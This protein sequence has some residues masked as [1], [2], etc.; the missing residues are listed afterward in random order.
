MIVELWAALDVVLKM[1]IITELLHEDFVC[2][3][4][5]MEHH[6]VCQ[7]KYGHESKPFLNMP[8]GVAGKIVQTDGLYQVKEYISFLFD[9]LIKEKQGHLKNKDQPVP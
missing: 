7:I 5:Y 8:D 6:F 9:V 1:F 2:W 3:R 4:K